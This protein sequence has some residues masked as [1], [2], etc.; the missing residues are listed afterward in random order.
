MIFTIYNQL[1]G[2]NY[3]QN[4]FGKY[5]SKALEKMYNKTLHAVTKSRQNS[6]IGTIYVYD[7]AKRVSLHE[8][9]SM[10]SHTK[11]SLILT[12]TRVS[13]IQIS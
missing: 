8:H 9:F 11:V 4:R 6:A 2:G 3:C 12:H 13:F 7:V 10:E 1:A 5:L